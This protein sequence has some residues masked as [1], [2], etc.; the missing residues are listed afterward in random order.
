MLEIELW[1]DTSYGLRLA[2]ECWVLA[3]SLALL[4]FS[5]E[6][7]YL[8]SPLQGGTVSFFFFFFFNLPTQIMGELV[9]VLCTGMYLD[10]YSFSC[11]NSDSLTWIF[12]LNCVLRYMQHN[13]FASWWQTVSTHLG[14][15]R[16]WT[17]AAPVEGR[18]PLGP[19]FDSAWLQIVLSCLH[20]VGWLG[21]VG[22]HTALR[23]PRVHA[24]DQITLP[25]SKL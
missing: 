21:P 14:R 8:F 9:L 24:A 17:A 3:G 16:V 4:L 18:L 15:T 13:M 19:S 23:E 20:E 1:L 5:E 25:L 22:S 10:G 7:F 2:V 6:A 12:P 11:F